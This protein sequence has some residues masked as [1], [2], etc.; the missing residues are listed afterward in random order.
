MAMQNEFK[1]GHENLI[2]S[3]VNNIFESLEL[4]EKNIDNVHSKVVRR[5]RI[6]FKDMT[7]NY[8]TY[9]ASFRKEILSTI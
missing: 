6:L 7:A 2:Q 5:T 4:K 3:V 1:K 9:K 8:Q